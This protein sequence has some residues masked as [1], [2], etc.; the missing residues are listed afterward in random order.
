MMSTSIHEASHAAAAIMLGRPVEYLWRETGHALVG[1]EVG[2]V[3][4]PDPRRGP[5]P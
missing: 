5:V 1:D 2:H 3:P 4:R